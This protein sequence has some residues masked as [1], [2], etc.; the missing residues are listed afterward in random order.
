MKGSIE[1]KIIIG[2]LG[3]VLLV[4]GS[5][6]AFSY[7][8]WPQATPANNRANPIL[9]VAIA[10]SFSLLLLGWIYY[11]L[12]RANHKTEE[13]YRTITRN[14]PNGTVALFDKDLRYTLVE[15][16]GLTEV[17]LTNECLAGKTIWETLPSDVAVQI[18][19]YYRAVLEGQAQVFE[20][21][22]QGRIYLV[23]LLP[24]R[25]K[26]GEVY[27]GLS[28]SQNISDRKRT[29]LALLEERNFVSA[30]LNAANALIVVFDH[31]DRI[32]HFN[33]ACEQITGY[34]FNEVKGKYVWDLF[35]MPEDIEPLKTIFEEL[36]S[37]Q[38]P[39]EHENYWVTRD[40]NRRTIAW[41]NTI[42]LTAEGSLKYIISIGIDITERK[43][44]EVMRRQLEREQELSKLRTRFFSLASHEFRTPLST[45]LASVQLLQ[46]Y[47]DEWPEDKKLRNLY[48]IESAAKRMR[49]MLDDI[50]T[51]NRA[52]TGRLEFNPI[53]LDI[54]QFCE[55]LMAEMQIHA[56]QHH[57]LTFASEGDCKNAYLDPQL[58]RYILMNL[59]SNAIKYSPEGGEVQLALTGTPAA[60]TFKV[61][62]RGI[63]IP[64]QDQPH[65]FE[66]FHRGENI[67]SI[68]GSGLGLTVVKNCTDIHGGSITLT[69]EVGVGTSF[70]VTI[71]NLEVG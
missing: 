41:Y 2:G 20:S 31:E 39:N 57:Q 12:V 10:N 37:G 8:N 65:L 70:T 58:L 40:G 49:Q 29:E 22:H 35:L 55:Q 62:D 7:W 53:V 25:N 63:G 71:P 59:L 60:T 61:S 16:T 19:P 5:T 51:I 45:I 17:G 26:Q 23:H 34:S 14:F 18:E 44:A 15:G 1:Q 46:F 28:M 68:P 50:L 47:G 4:L 38:F 66:A 64:P 6:I 43:Q 9:L 27:A 42:L 13:L 11:R 33:R 52:E 48:R 24:L 32:V 30:I 54:E 56:T 67:S 36:Q 3:L 69:S 21:P